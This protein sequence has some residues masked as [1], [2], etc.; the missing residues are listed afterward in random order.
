MLLSDRVQLMMVCSQCSFIDKAARSSK[1]FFFLSGH[2][3]VCGFCRRD[4]W[5][6]ELVPEDKLLALMFYAPEQAE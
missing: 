3:R 2:D 1:C 6:E 4:R 5:K